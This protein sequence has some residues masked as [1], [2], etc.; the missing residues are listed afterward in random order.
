MRMSRAASVARDEDGPAAARLCDDVARGVVIYALPIVMVVANKSALATLCVAAGLCLVATGLRARSLAEFARMLVPGWSTDMALALAFAGLAILSTL[1]SVNPGE[2]LFGLGETAI[3]IGAAVIVLRRL[4]A[5]PREALIRHLCAALIVCSALICIE[6]A[7]DMPLRR[8]VGG[9]AQTFQY[10]RAVEVV[11]LYATGLFAVAALS[12]RRL[13]VWAAL[14]AVATAVLASDSG[15]GVAALLVA[16][17]AAALARID[18]TL[19]RRAIFATLLFA[20]A[21]APL[22]VSPLTAV[23]PKRVE[24]ALSNAHV[25]ER[26]AIWRAYSDVVA[27]R[28]LVGSGFGA[29]SSVA[30][31]RFL[32]S[33]R[34]DVRAVEATHPH[35][36]FLQIW[37]DLGVVG[38]LLA[39][40]LLWRLFAAVGRAPRGRQFALLIF[41]TVAGAIGLLSHSVWQGS[42]IAAAAGALAVARLIWPATGSHA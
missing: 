38:A 21:S 9:R 18:L 30:A 34:V 31:S 23:T 16:A 29:S 26:L 37:V 27:R 6:L 25:A 4:A 39:G 8:L 1:W 11:V 41:L 42:L 33:P 32:D 19:A 13:L 7:I 35:H 40:A 14:A 22:I 17:A 15:A 24:T 20:V 2:T 10:N 36:A 5:Y 3:A 28:P 12:T